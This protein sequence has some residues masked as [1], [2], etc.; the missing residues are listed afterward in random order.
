MISILVA[1]GFCACL[2]WSVWQHLYIRWLEASRLR[3]RTLSYNWMLRDQVI[4]RDYWATSRED[5]NAREDS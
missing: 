3:W 2:A 5:W 4:E 1:L